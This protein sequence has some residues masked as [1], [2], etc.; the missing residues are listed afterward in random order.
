MPLFHDGRRSLVLLTE[1]PRKRVAGGKGRTSRGADDWWMRPVA[2]VV[3]D[4]DDDIGS[5]TGGWVVMHG[6][7]HCSE[8]VQGQ[9]SNLGR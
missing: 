8:V 3:V 2:D 4:D 9:V 1:A 7:R 5:R 6:G